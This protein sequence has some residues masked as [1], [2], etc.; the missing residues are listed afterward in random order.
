MTNTGAGQVKTSIYTPKRQPGSRALDAARPVLLA[1]ALLAVA[2]AFSSGLLASLG[3]SPQFS[4]TLAGSFALYLATRPA[5]RELL[6]TLVLGLA[7]RLAYGAM[8]R[9]EPYFGSA[10]IGF[11]GFVGIA[12]LMVLTYTALRSHR[13]SVLGAAVFF[14]FV[15]ILVGF[16]LPVTNRLSPVTFDSHLLA[17]DGAIGFQPS[18]ILG[19]MIGGHPRRGR[20][21]R[22]SLLR[23]TTTD[24][25]ARQ[26]SSAVVRRIAGQPQMAARNIPW[27]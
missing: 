17:A 12:A 15:S 3:H 26:R 13:F 14:P 4:F 11:A 21:P 20:I 8:F 16:I 6:L 25:G 9:V 5:R 7:L 27:R 2:A 18:F 22:R 23:T 24:G 1:L 19:R 10:W